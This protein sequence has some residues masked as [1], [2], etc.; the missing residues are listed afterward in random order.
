MAVVDWDHD[1]DLDIW[2]HN[3]T[4]P[5]V[6]YMRNETSEANNRNAFIS[7]RLHGT[8]SNRDGIG[9]R[10]EVVLENASAGKLI[11][12]LYAGDSFVSQSSKWLHFGL[13]QNP[14]I[15][16]VIVNWPGGTKQI[17]TQIMPNKRYVLTQNTPNAQE[18]SPPTRTVTLSP[19]P[20]AAERTVDRNR[21]LVSSPVPMPLMPYQRFNDPTIRTIKTNSQPLLIN[22]WAMWCPSCLE[23]LNTF[24][25]NE[26]EIRST[27]LNILALNVDDLTDKGTHSADA[28]SF[29]NRISFPF[30]RGSA[31]AELLDKIE[32]MH[33]L[34]FSWR[35]EFELPASYLLDGEGKLA[36]V[37]RGAVDLDQVLN[38]VRGLS[39]NREAWRRA[40]LPIPGRSLSPQGDMDIKRIAHEFRDIY[41]HDNVRYLQMALSQYAFHRQ[42]AEQTGEDVKPWDAQISSVNYNLAHKLAELGNTELAIDRYRRSVELAPDFAEAH[43]NLANHLAD[44]KKWD[45]A[46]SHYRQADKVKPGEYRI[47]MQL[48]KALYMS[49]KP[50]EAIFYYEQALQERPSSAT[51]QTRVGILYDMTGQQQKA[52]HHYRLA[53]ELNTKSPEPYNGL[54]WIL[55]TSSDKA[56][57]DP[58]QAVRLAQRAVELSKHQDP[59]T[60]DT[61]ATAYAAVG[62]FEQAVQIS[63]QAMELATAGKNKHLLAQIRSRLGLFQQSKPYAM[64]TDIG[65]DDSPS[66]TN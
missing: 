47:Q 11:Q 36:A 37:Y 26:Q 66:G 41:S 55:A 51:L 20:L 4:A 65:S 5:R 61:L 22:F 32:I 33:E 31:T 24:T 48:A 42:R 34:L 3:R 8:T 1:G 9:A 62:Q 10:V 39:G 53:V 43:T 38:D 40:S 18:W 12:T 19:A 28:Q 46:I 29:L 7:L 21:G 52:A 44:L 58:E 14:K 23:E 50:K 15:D 2:L 56:G 6:R 27:G 60:L 35:P 25:E 54:A 17:F 49:G 16:H 45:E 57:R 13:G 59:S 64:T 30:T 63:K